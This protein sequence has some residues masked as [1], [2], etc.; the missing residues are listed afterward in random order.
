MLGVAEVGQAELASE[1][2]DPVAVD[3]RHPEQE[4]A[5]PCSLPEGA[6]EL[7]TRGHVLEH[8][9]QD[10]HVE[11]VVGLVVER[12]GPDE[13]HP[14]MRESRAREGERPLRAVDAD[15][16]GASPLGDVVRELALAGTDVENTLVRSDVLDE[17]VVVAGQPVLD[18]NAVV[19]IDRAPVHRVESVSVHVEQLAHRL[20][21]IGLGAYGAEPQ[22]E[23]RTPEA[24]REEEANRPERDTASDSSRDAPRSPVLG[25]HATRA[26]R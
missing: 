3:H 9:R 17:E 11:S 1:R 13:A 6:Q 20:S 19:V 14:R 10:G 15:H 12:V 21:A 2:Y 8:V 5:D 22:T 25:R 16:G 4:P 23:E 24:K 7:D 26:F 18:V